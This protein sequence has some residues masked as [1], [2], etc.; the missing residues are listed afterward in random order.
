MIQLVVFISY[1]VQSL[2]K[3]SVGAETEGAQRLRKKRKRKR[4]TLDLKTLRMSQTA[5][6]I[7]VCHWSC[8][9][10]AMYILHSDTLILTCLC[11]QQTLMSYLGK[12]AVGRSRN[13]KCLNICVKAGCTRTVCLGGSRLTKRTSSCSGVTFSRR[14][15]PQSRVRTP[16][17][18]WSVPGSTKL[19]Y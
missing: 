13:R 19:Q 18:L 9:L 14:T 2:W 15:G 1:Q 7:K 17:L 11:F 5:S 3:S 4:A 16:P 10:T 6:E 12:A 8:S